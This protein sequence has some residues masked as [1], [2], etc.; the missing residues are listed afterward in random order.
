MTKQEDDHYK[1]SCVLKWLNKVFVLVFVLV[2]I[3]AKQKFYV[4]WDGAEDGVFTSW[5]ACQ[6]A[7][8]GYS[9]AKYKSFKS[10]EEAEAA[11]EMGYDAWIELEKEKENNKEE[12]N[13]TQSTTSTKSTYNIPPAAINDSI[14]VDAACSGNP[15]KMEYRGV[16]LKTGKEIF[17]YGP[18]FGTNNIG[19]FLA[20]VHG[21]ALLK[22]KGLHTMPIYSDSVNA[23]LWVRKKKCKT[24]LERN[25]KTEALY[26]LI[27]RAEKWLNENTYSNPIIKWPTDQWGEIPADFGRK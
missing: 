9:N 20:I 10:E 22:Q 16:Y 8:S 3:M 5:E 13:S 19:E 15:G 12:E 2:N 23:Q 4:V 11:F 21:L 1:I 18:V 25:E 6:Q 17:H 27:E 14:A 24:T 7:V 26:Q